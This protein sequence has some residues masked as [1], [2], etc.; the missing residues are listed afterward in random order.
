VTDK[1]RVVVC[2]VAKMPRVEMIMPGLEP[3]QEIIGGY[4]EC[5][6]LNEGI[7]LWCDEEGL[8]KG[9]PLNREIRQRAPQPSAL[10]KDAFVIDARMDKSQ[11]MAKPGQ[12]GVH[13]IHGTFL[14]ART[15]EDGSLVGLSDEDLKTVSKLLGEPVAVAQQKP[16]SRTPEERL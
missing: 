10:F 11:P 8:L 4:V 2:G 6:A 7:D 14:F 5:L 9:L 1:I 12:M 13:R 15:D 3:L 16:R